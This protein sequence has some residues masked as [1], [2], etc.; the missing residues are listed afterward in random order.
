M[1]RQNKEK[2][3]AKKSVC[4]KQNRGTQITGAKSQPLT[5]TFCKASIVEEEREEEK[6][7]IRSGEEEGDEEKKE[8]KTKLKNCSCGR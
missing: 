3:S 2:N 8:R 4:Q 7:K 5:A 1:A 6:R